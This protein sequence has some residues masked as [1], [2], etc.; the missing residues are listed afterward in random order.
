M[1]YL[2]SVDQETP[3]K[4]LELQNTLWQ[5]YLNGSTGLASGISAMP[6]MH[7]AMPALFAVSIWHRSRVVSMLFWLFTLGILVGSVHLGWH[8]AL[9]GYASILLT[10]PIWWGAGT[11]TGWWYDRTRAWRWGWQPL[12]EGPRS[13]AARGGVA[14]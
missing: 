10:F 9:D 14:P 13:R 3:L 11:V 8:Y 12:P 5:G 1:A 2:R 6:S 7:V 4:A